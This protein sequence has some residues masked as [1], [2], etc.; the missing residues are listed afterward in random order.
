MS[1]DRLMHLQRLSGYEDVAAQLGYMDRE[2]AYAARAI[3]LDDQ[4]RAFDLIASLRT[5]LPPKMGLRRTVLAAAGFY[6]HLKGYVLEDYQRVLQ[7]ATEA[8]AVWDGPALAMDR[9]E[10]AINKEFGE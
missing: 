7:D 6:G 4:Y 3:Y 1:L 5:L 8:L 2:P 9:Y 10:S